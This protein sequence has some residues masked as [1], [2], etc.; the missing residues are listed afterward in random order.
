MSYAKIFGSDGNGMYDHDQLISIQR[1]GLYPR[2]KHEHSNG[3]SG[4]VGLSDIGLKW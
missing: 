4:D 3:K 2:P 1:E